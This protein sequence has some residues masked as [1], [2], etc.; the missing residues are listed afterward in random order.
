MSLI[1]KNFAYKSILTVSSF[2]INFITFPYVSRML[3]VEN[4]GLV[5]FVDNTVNYFLLFATMGINILGVREIAAVKN[6]LRHRSR[7]FSNL[8]GMNIAFTLITLVIYMICIMTIPKLRQYDELFYIGTSKIICAAFLVEWFFTGI[9]NFRY[10]T[11]RSIFIKCLYVIAVFLFIRSKEDYKIY[12]IMTIAVV[13]V[14][15]LINVTYVRRFIIMR[16]KDL[17][18]GRFYKKNIVL[19]I[20]SIMTSMYLTFNVMF[21]GFVSDNVEVGYYTTAFKLYSVILGLFAA[22][23]NVM[24]PRM[25]VL[26]SG[27]EKEHF[28]QLA[29][30]SFHMICIFCIPMIV[31]SIILAPQLVNVL[32][33]AGYE[34]A[35]MPMRIIMP[36]ALFV[37]MAQ[38]LAIQVLTPMR[39]D[40]VL[41]M[42]SFIGACVGITLNVLLVP[43]MHSVGSSIVLL[44]AEISVTIT[45]IAYIM[46]YKVMPISFTNIWCGVALS[47]PCAVVCL[48]CRYYIVNPFLL[49]FVAVVVTGIIVLSTYCFSMKHI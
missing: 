4:V 41:L 6:S 7:T 26:L 34:G 42:A 25:S 37:G 40:R 24:L 18:S 1:K 48:V 36:A 16:F 38:V 46:Y 44:F 5:N 29:N 10:I 22:F 13:V 21:L 27:G 30:K 12:F 14:N 47:V 8:L 39:N 2:L 49:L 3:G 9:E 43:S 35:I 19:G 15:A 23:T 33:G 31:C 20:Y 28:Q 11:L 45:Y 32:S 17:S